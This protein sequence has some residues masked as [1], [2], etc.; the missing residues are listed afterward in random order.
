MLLAI[1]SVTE[2]LILKYILD[3]QYTSTFRDI[4]RLTFDKWQQAKLYFLK[5]NLWD[6]NWTVLRYNNLRE[7]YN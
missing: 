3:L 1:L 7:K 4:E 6:G 2:D 5:N